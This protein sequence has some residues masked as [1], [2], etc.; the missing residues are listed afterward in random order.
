MFDINDPKP[1]TEVAIKK[2][3]GESETKA[4]RTKRRRGFSIGFFGWFI[5][6][7]LYF[8]IVFASHLNYVEQH[9]YVFGILNLIVIFVL[10]FYNRNWYAYGIIAAIIVIA[11]GALMNNGYVPSSIDILFA[12]IYPPLPSFLYFFSLGR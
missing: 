12:I 5:L 3:I 11:I 2:E 4:G 10:F 7:S 6:G 8:I 9:S 1:N